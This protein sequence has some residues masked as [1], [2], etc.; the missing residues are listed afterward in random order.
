[1]HP[2]SNIISTTFMNYDYKRR[3][4]IHGYLI[5]MADSFHEIKANWRKSLT[6]RLSGFMI[7]TVW[8]IFQT[9]HSLVTDWRN[10][11]SDRLLHRFTLVANNYVK[12]VN[13]T[14][15]LF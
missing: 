6:L 13:I 1:M 9:K 3:L 10:Q 14:F 7:V 8:V 11:S 2:N 12:T 5:F 4:S 15:K